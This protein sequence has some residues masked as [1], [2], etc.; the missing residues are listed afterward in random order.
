MKCQLGP[1]R[2]EVILMWF[3]LVHAWYFH[4]NSNK[5]TLTLGK[6]EEALSWLQVQL[7]FWV[8]L[9]YKNI[10]CVFK[11]KTDFKK[12]LTTVTRTTCGFIYRKQNVVA[13]NNF[14]FTFQV[15]VSCH[16]IWEN[17]PLR[18]LFFIER[19]KNYLL[20]FQRSPQFGRFGLNG[21]PRIVSWTLNFIPVRCWR[22]THIGLSNF[23]IPSTAGVF[24]WSRW[25]TRLVLVE[26]TI[27]FDKCQLIIG[28]KFFKFPVK[29]RKRIFHPT[30]N[31][32]S[33]IF[34]LLNKGL[35]FIIVTMRVHRTLEYVRLPHFLLDN[36][37]KIY[38]L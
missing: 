13:K 5:Q 12:A 34:E 25:G 15:W 2:K 20:A 35:T 16:N 26:S 19:Q 1:G 31:F 18:E 29:A 24:R 4:L 22:S 33:M 28:C 21:P 7:Q 17:I 8:I 38:L 6:A 37:L 32:E 30:K 3:T 11:K 27:I 36:Q 9:H 10:G 14:R 23:L